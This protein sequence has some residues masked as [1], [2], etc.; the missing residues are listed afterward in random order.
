[1]R[2][3]IERDSNENLWIERKTNVGKDKKKH[4]HGNAPY[5]TNKAVLFKCLAVVTKILW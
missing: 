2:R 1:V 4:I 5:T 3:E